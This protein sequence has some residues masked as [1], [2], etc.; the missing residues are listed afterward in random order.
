MHA[1]YRKAQQLMCSSWQ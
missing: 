1:Y